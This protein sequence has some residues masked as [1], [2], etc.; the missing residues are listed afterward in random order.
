MLNMVNV[1]ELS[2]AIPEVVRSMLEY[3]EIAGVL[4]EISD[5]LPLRLNKIELSTVIDEDFDSR[6]IDRPVVAAFPVNVV[7]CANRLPLE[8]QTEMAPPN[9]AVLPENVELRTTRLAAK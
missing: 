8:P 4:A 7:F 6:K 5:S 9:F 1:S 2:A 3:T